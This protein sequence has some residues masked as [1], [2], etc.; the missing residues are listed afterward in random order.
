MMKWYLLVINV[1]TLQLQQVIL[2]DIKSIKI[3]EWD[4][5][6]NSVIMLEL[7]QEVLKY[8]LRVNMKE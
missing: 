2:E 4:N 7:K 1:I 6:V 3:K 5:L 8:I